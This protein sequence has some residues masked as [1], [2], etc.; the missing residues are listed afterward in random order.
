M[1]YKGMDRF[2]GAAGPRLRDYAVFAVMGL[3]L[4]YALLAGLRTIT[5]P[6]TFWQLAT[7]RYI[8]QHHLIPKTDVLSYTARGET[9]IYPA[10]SQLFLYLVYMVGG[11]AGLSW[12]NAIAC[13]ATAGIAFC[14]E[15]GLAAAL[16]A[17]L[18]VPKIAYRTTPR[19][20]LFSTVLFAILLVVLW[21]HFS[22]RR[23]PLWLVPLLFLIWANT[24]LG[25]IAGFALLIAYGMM[26]LG[27]FLVAERAAPAYARL[28]SALPWLIAAVPLT[29]F[30]PWGWGIYRAVLRQ[31]RSMPE[32]QNVIAEWRHVPLNAATLG[33]ALAWR[34]PNSSYFWLLAL[35][36]LAMAI[37]LKRRSFG[38][39]AVLLGSAYLSL[40]H[41][42]FQGLFAVV[43]I[44]VAAPFLASLATSR[45]P[46]R[47]VQK[48][49]GRRSMPADKRLTKSSLTGYAPFIAATVLVATV[50]LLGIR[51][52]DLV[53][54]RAYIAAGDVN[55]FGVGI[56]SWYPERAAAFVLRE[57]LP[58]NIFHDYNL[59]GFLSFQLGPQ[60][61]DYIDARSLP[62]GSLMAEQRALMQQSPDSPAWQQE[63]DKRGIN[64]LMFSLARYWGLGAGGLRQ[65][66]TSADWKTVYL[67]EVAIV[68]VR[69]RPEVLELIRRLPVDCQQVRF[70]PPPTLAADNS[71]RG[72][73][74]LFNFYAHA[75]SI[76]FKLSRDSEAALALDRALQMFPQEPFLHQIRGQVYQAN[77]QPQEAEREYL[78]S[79]R[80]KPVE[81]TWYALARLYSSQHRY[82]EAARAFAQAAQLS[83]RPSQYY[84]SLGTV[85]LAMSQP[86][87]ALSAFDAAAANSDYEPPETKGD[88][89]AQVAKGRASA[90][91]SLRTSQWFNH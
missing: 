52:Y 46:E 33:E 12:L 14:G 7:G 69:D 79:A 73:A 83:V 85:Y 72:R 57:K 2:S 80:L 86:Q 36:V 91:N 53:T 10:F 37:A 60:Y 24:H 76:L 35:T 49:G 63:A 39:A 5:D 28:R 8:F 59:G 56:S 62:F 23:A 45:A 21:R 68:L 89:D 54:Q 71:T 30:N 74:E 88:I 51:G 87:E 47:V 32:Q 43:A 20:D 66:C 81:A 6:D 9:W 77:G 82:P 48:S 70:E 25:F 15:A 64:T 34:N 40:R 55:L 11:F 42:R 4:V 26:E 19:A 3:V 78:V 65:F 17:M 1:S 29:L 18:A 22:G 41:I 61:L 27:E 84:I 67:D 58:A 75:G 31:E 50:L 90:W 13:A 44:V 38:P 16:L